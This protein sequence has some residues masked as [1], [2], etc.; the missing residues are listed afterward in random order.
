MQLD[1][2]YKEEIKARQRARIQW[3]QRREHVVFSFGGTKFLLSRDSQKHWR[4]LARH[5]Y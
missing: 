1:Q 2:L 4:M 5:I 3:N